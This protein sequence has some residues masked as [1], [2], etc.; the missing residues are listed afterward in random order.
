MAE[1]QKGRFFDGKNDK[2]KLQ[3]HMPSAEIVAAELGKAKSIDDFEKDGIF[4]KL[5]S[6]TIEEM[7]EAELSDHLGYEKYEAKGRNSGNSRNGHYERQLK[8]SEGETTIQVPR[9]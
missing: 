3:D 5:F 6:K 1:R 2:K 7:M 9:D 4:A 8:T